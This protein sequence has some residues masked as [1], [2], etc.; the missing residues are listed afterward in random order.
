MNIFL[1]IGA[2]Y[3]FINQLLK[4][5]DIDFK[6]YEVLFI[7]LSTMIFLI[8]GIPSLFEFFFWYASSSVH[9]IGFLLFLFFLNLNIKVYLQK[10]WQIIPAMILVLLLNG[11]NELFLGFTNFTLILLL[12]INYVKLKLIDVRLIFLNLFSW[13]TTL[14]VVLSPGT[15]A[16]RSQFNYGGDIFVSAKV[17]ILYGGKF[18]LE[19]IFEWPAILFFLA[20]FLFILRASSGKK[21]QKNIPVLPFMIISYLGFISLYFIK[22]Y[23][24]GLVERDSGRIGDLLHMV[25]YVLILVNVLNLALYFSK[26]DH[27]KSIKI[28]ITPEILLILFFIGIALFNDNFRNIRLDIVSGDLDRFRS[29]INER[30]NILNS[31]KGDQLVLHKIDDTRVLKSGDRLLMAEDWDWLRQCYSQYLRE[32]KELRIESVEIIE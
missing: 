2:I 17:A 24:T 28:S 31:F 11:N 7:G 4:V 27:F 20:F 22:F 1:S 6:S 23:A 10:R 16:R 14:V 5:F 21:V 32:I 18:I 15:E 19:N 26:K 29:E 3:V 12:V 30:D 13:L 8:A 25:L 9:L